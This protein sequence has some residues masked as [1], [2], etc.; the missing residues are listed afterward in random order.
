MVPIMRGRMNKG[1]GTADRWIVVI[2]SVVVDRQSWLVAD[3]A[4]LFHIGARWIQIAVVLEGPTPLREIAVSARRRRDLNSPCGLSLIV[5][6]LAELAH[7][8]DVELSDGSD[9]DWYL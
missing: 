7:L 9:D 1:N 6:F 3:A 8:L 2:V 5:L 4:I